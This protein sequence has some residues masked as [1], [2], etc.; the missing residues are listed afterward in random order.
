MALPVFLIAGRIIGVAL[1]CG[2][3]LYATIA[4]IG[5][6]SRFG[7]IDLPPG[8]IGLEQWLLIGAAAALFL[9]E[10]V[11]HAI[12][13]VDAAWEGL[14]TI[15][16]PVG[17]AALALVALDLAPWY[18][19]L[20][21]VLVAGTAAF[22][23]HAARIGLRV[24]ATAGRSN[25]LL[26]SVAENLVAAAIGLA[27]LAVAVVALIVVGLFTVLLAV[28][29]PGLWRA[30][31]FAGRAMVARVRGF[32]GVRGWRQP[33]ALPAPLRA[34]VP[35]REIGRPEAKAVRAALTGGVSGAWRNGW[36]VLDGRTA[37]FLYWRQLRPVRLVLP[38]ATD[39]VLRHGFLA[40]IVEIRRDDATFTLHLLKDGPPAEVTVGALQLV[41]E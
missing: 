24:V 10:L 8:L 23:A 27:S 21:G 13:L 26:I 31:G 22:A 32:L 20:A 18:W 25:R 39:A 12:P 7:L 3:N 36:L 5:L 28:V 17:A 33:D 6:A 19:Q 40:D 29:G 38:R 41:I 30:A 15:I 34:H 11:A 4:V 37:V 16:R 9:A 1:A 35:P 14:H 2:I